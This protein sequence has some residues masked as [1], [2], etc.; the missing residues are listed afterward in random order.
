MNSE[1]TAREFAGNTAQASPV[2]VFAAYKTWP[3][4]IRRKLSLHDLRRMGGWVA[5][6]VIREPTQDECSRI[7][8]EYQMR[9]G[10][11]WGMCMFKAVRAVMFPADGSK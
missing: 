10:E 9:D 6:Q 7:L 11:C 5:S 1:N 3:D 8:R 2:D 4:D